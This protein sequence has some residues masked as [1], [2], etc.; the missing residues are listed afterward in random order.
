MVKI[1]IPIFQNRVS[2]VLD[3]CRHIIVAAIEKDAE[4]DREQVF[5]G[6]IALNDRCRIFKKLG[7]TVIICS[8]VSATF[9]KLLEQAKFEIVDG[10]AGDVQ[11]VLTAYLDGRLDHPDFYMPGFKVKDDRL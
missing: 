10:I 9:G 4:I 7:I 5:I 11:D 3:S 1:A 8:G 6:D 2:P